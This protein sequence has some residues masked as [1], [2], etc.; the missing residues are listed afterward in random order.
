MGKRNSLQDRLFLENAGKDSRA[1]IL[2]FD[3]FAE[4]AI[5][6]GIWKGLP[7]TVETRY[8]EKC[9][10]SDGAGV[11][12]YDDVMEKW[13]A[14]RVLRDGYLDV[15]GNPVYRTARGAN[16]Y[17]A[18]LNDENSVIIYNNLL[19]QSSVPAAEYY[20][21]RLWDIDRAIDVNA[22]AQKTPVLILCDE[23]KRLSLINM[24]QKY[25]GNQPAI[26]GEKD[27]LK[28]VEFTTLNT[29][30]PYVSDK[31]YELRTNIWNEALTYFGVPNMSFE[32]GERLIKDEVNR[33]NGGTFASRYS[34]L[35][36]RENA[37]AE[38]KSKLGLD[39]TYTFRDE[40]NE[41]PAEQDSA[42]KTEEG[43]AENG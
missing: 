34:R 43:V 14:L 20:A 35:A 1:Y 12:Y 26:F 40:M 18:R 2:Y 31:L 39:V 25:D 36:A 11:L 8:L 37:C 9:L 10:F 28:D 41:K 21:T 6:S 17:Q 38:I 22:K 13:L 27:Y 23:K 16:G 19:R 15:Y 7:E 4:I 5:S 30:A 33:L 29:A 32:K 3:R 24:Y 42:E